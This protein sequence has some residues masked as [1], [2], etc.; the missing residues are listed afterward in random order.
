MTGTS[1]ATL[2]RLLT[3]ACELEHGLACSYL[4]AAMS[5]KHDPDEGGIDWRGQQLCRLWAAQLYFVAAQEMLHLAQVWNLLA[6][7]GGTPYYLRPNFPQ[8]ARFYPIN[9]PIVAERFSLATLD[10]FIAYERPA[11]LIPA[12]PPGVERPFRTV[13]ELYALIARAFTETR[14]DE[15]FIGFADR[16]VGP[17]L[18]DFPQLIKVTGRASA[19]AAVDLIVRQGEGLE[20]DR[21]D[22]H[23]GVFKDVRRG[24]LAALNEAEKQGRIFDP[25]RPCIAN[26]VAEGVVEWAGS[27]ANPITDPR[28]AAVAEVFDSLYGLMLRMLQYVFDNGT[29]DA[30]TLSQFGKTAIALMAS[31]IKPLG[32]A[33]MRL[34]AGL[35]YEGE[36]A[37]PGF[38]LSRHVPLPAE[39]AAARRVAAERLGELAQKLDLLVVDKG[40]QPIEL[41]AANRTLAEAVQNFSH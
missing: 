35:S 39:P 29:S 21:R 5:L 20:V 9:V 11:Q 7:I 36:T 27:G 1:R 30:P 8:P 6:A 28:S 13:G 3:Q 4:F 16:Q 33:L 32:E 38:V 22:C 25:V 41:V 37:G 12:P 24:F 15:L 26:P 23:F 10:R 34:P 2:L 40:P 18:V 14:E 31:V 19:L 17:E